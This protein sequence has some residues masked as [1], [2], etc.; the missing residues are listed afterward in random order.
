[1][2]ASLAV[3]V[4]AATYHD[5]QEGETL[6]DIA[7][8]AG[9]GVDTLAT[10]NGISNPDLIVVG[11]RLALSQAADTP[12]STSTTNGRPD[13]DH[14]VEPGETLSEIAENHGVSLAAVLEHN[15]QFEGRSLWVGEVVRVVYSSGAATTTSTTTSTGTDTTTNTPVPPRP[16]YTVQAGDTLSEIAAAQGV[17]VAALVAA[18]GITTDTAL[19]IGQQLEIPNAGGLPLDLL[20]S[21]E[22]MALMPVF[23]EMAAT[24]GVAP[25]LL[26][27][28]AWFESGWNNNVVSSADAIGIGQILPVTADFVS[29]D[30]LGKSLDPYV[31]RDNIELSAAY[32]RY[33]I[34]QTD[35]DLRLAV[36]SYY[37][38]LTAVRRHGVFTSSEF[39][40]EG[41]LKLR[42][43][44]A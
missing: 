24:Y 9:V 42:E 40:V 30:L 32:M 12:Q 10:L 11:Q 18:N 14:V 23:D 22:K 38:G 34:A 35:G 36:A 37:Q 5:V 15:P 43:R 8:R 28:L 41:I 3:P 44:F 16:R 13:H 25:E 2:A 39:Y 7:L 29:N 19:Q 33:L 1:M 26:K 21:P 17:S 6:S 4:G 27:A 20:N 31:P